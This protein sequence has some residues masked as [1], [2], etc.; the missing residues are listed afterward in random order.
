MISRTPKSRYADH[1]KEWDELTAQLAASAAEHPDLETKRTMLE[2]V[3]AQAKDLTLQQARFQ[4]EKQKISQQLRPLLREGMRIATALRVNLKLAYGNQSDD[5][6]KFGIQPFRGRTKKEG[7]P[8]ET[9]T[10]QPP[11]KP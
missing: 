1:I 5:L 2:K 3:L 8:E 9:P 7:S 11:A 6:V 10:P 4:A